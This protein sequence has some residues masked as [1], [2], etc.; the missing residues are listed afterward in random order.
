MLLLLIVA[1]GAIG[2]LII[3]PPSD[4]IR[5]TVVEQVKA[6]TGRDLIVAGPASF[7]IYPGLGVSLQDVSLSA[8]P[9][10][11]GQVVTMKA[12]NVSVKA[13]PLLSRKVEVDSLILKD[14]VFDLKIDKSGQRNWAFAEPQTP[15]RYAQATDATTTDANPNLPAR[16]AA[17]DHLRFDDVRIEN[18][19]FNFS[20]ERNGK[21]QHVET[22]NVK[23]ALESLDSPMSAEGNLAY[24]GEKIDFNG[25]LTNPR[26]AI[27]TNAARLAFNAS[28]RHVATS[29]DGSVALKD[30]A[31]LAGKVHV[32]SFSARNLAA[33]LGTELPPVPGFGPLSIAG[34]LKT[35]GN[36]TTF[37]DATFALDGGTATGTIALT[38]QG[39]RPHIRADLKISELNLNTYMIAEG[40]A[41]LAVEPA[42]ANARSPAKA[43][44]APDDIEKLLNAPATKVYGAVQRA[45]WSSEAINLA[46]LGVADADAKLHVGKLTYKDIKVGQSALTVALKN[47]VMKTAFD[48][49]QLY[50]GRG[51][52]VVTVDGTAKAAAV[53]AKFSLAGMSAQPFLQDAASMNWLSG[54]ANVTLDITGTGTSQ[55]QLVESVNG[56]ASVK[57]SDGAIVG[58]NLAGAI[59]QIQQGKLPNLQTSSSEKTD[60]SE[61]NGTFNIINGVAQNQDLQLIS[62]LLR[63]TG[64][65]NIHLAPRTIDYTVKPKLVASLEG[66]QG[67]AALSGLEIPVRITGSWDKPKYEPDLKGVLADPDKA[68]GAIKEAAKKFKGK[69]TDEIVDSLLGGDGSEASKE[70]S[71]TKAK[72]LLNKFLNPQ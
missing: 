50:G 46:L 66:Q 9:G 63:V 10:M 14:P 52:G 40:S 8:P 67:N 64:A 33:W 28:N 68:V 12:L 26:S 3:N 38:Q 55:L 34:T 69:N 16:T 23:L 35:Q 53:A 71:K 4:L 11:T 19:T 60:F 51:Q 29:Y 7:A 43:P 31:D 39:V 5:Q 1:G 72:N 65:G 24:R 6:R 47:R 32:K 62:P 17:I 36:V 44:G 41:P 70:S 61:L 37:T 42:P 20:D 13:L 22:I 15:V 59:R 18:G 45:G 56:K 58:F 48:D 27:E 30:G 49:I 21:T 2:F 57:F 25:K 54:K